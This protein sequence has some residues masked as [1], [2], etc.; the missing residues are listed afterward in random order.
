MKPILF[1]TEMV[2]AILDGRK[3]VTRRVVKPTPSKHARLELLGDRRHAMD[4]SIEIPGPNDHRI[5]TPPYLPGDTLYVRE[6][7]Q[8]WRAHRYEANADIQ[9]KAGGDGVRVCFANGGTDSIDRGD[10]DSFVEKWYP[11]GKWNPSIHMP[12]EA[13]RIFLR[14]ERVRAEHLQKAFFEPICPILEVQAEGIDIGDHCRRCIDNY[15][16]PC[17]VDTI[18]EDGSNL[19]DGECGMLDDPRDDFARLWDSTIK[20]AELKRYGWTANPWVWVIEFERCEKP[21]DEVL[22]EGEIRPC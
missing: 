13:A 15:G 8:V 17:C 16:E 5:Y 10:Y 22:K 14:V 12:K 19:Y 9:F 18:D 7:W 21:E 3:T 6:T 1:K 11:N 20:P 2:K 4:V